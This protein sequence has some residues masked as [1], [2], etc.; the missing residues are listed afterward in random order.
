MVEVL[1]NLKEHSIIYYQKVIELRAVIG[2]KYP[3]LSKE[4]AARL[5]AAALHQIID[6]NIKVFNPLVQLH[7]KTTLFQDTIKKEVFTV[8]AYDIFK[9]CTFL[10]NTDKDYI[11]KLTIWVN[12]Q[13]Q[14]QLLP[15]EVYTLYLRLKHELQASD[16]IT[17]KEQVPLSVPLNES[18]HPLMTSSK[19]ESIPQITSLKTSPLVHVLENLTFI[20]S[21][22]RT[23]VCQKTIL[24]A[25]ILLL[26]L[27][28]LVPALESNLIHVSGLPAETALDTSSMMTLDDETAPRQNQAMVK[29]PLHKSLQYK[30]IDEAAL[31]AWLDERNSLLS[32]DPYFTTILNI[33][34]EFNIN[35][36]LM[37]AITGQEQSF[38]PRS[39]THAD[40]IANNPFNV[41]GS[42]KRF[43]T[44]IDE[45][46]RIAARTL[47]N[48]GKDC[49]E[50]EDPIKWINRKYAEDPNWHLGVSQI[51]TSLEKAAGN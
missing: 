11:E 36:L 16:P 2:E 7:I 48:L 20:T 39:H 34:E 32:N 8:N 12:T 37:F 47:I 19:L 45:A 30:P 51:L 46:S 14:Q 1:E 33:A 4:D 25:C 27:I 44:D 28:I 18:S 15:E 29:S 35:P 5:L 6:K 17:P 31:W 40:L 13:Q 23:R 22:T 41:Y 3:Y 10:D 49:P 38:V 21:F 42:W 43:N 9:A 24:T 26:S 50:N